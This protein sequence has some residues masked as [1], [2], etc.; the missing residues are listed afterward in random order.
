MLKIRTNT[1]IERQH[2]RLY[3]DAS[4]NE[5]DHH[6]ELHRHLYLLIARTHQSCTTTTRRSMSFF[7]SSRI[8]YASIGTI[9]T[10]CLGYAIYFDYKRRHD[11]GFRKALKSESRRQLRLAKTEQEAEG[12]RSRLQIRALVDAANEEGYPRD[13]E[14][15]EAYFMQEV[16]QGEQMCQDGRLQAERTPARLLDVAFGVL[17]LVGKLRLIFDI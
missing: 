3:S 1:T 2:R 12:K 8:L 4:L 5:E 17:D 14:E 16:G 9:I 13:A 7:R 10:G 11:P 6:R 15:K